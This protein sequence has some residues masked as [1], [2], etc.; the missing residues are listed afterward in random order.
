MTAT[1]PPEDPPGPPQ[2]PPATR[3]TGGADW[4]PR[5]HVIRSHPGLTGQTDD[6]GRLGALV[7]SIR[8]GKGLSTRSLARRSTVARSTIQRLERGLLRPRRSLL[9]AV[10]NGLDP[11]RC[12]E[13]IGKLIE[14]AG[15]GMAPDT[16]RWLRRRRRQM[17][18]GWL[19]GDVP[20]PSPIARCIELHKRAD[21]LWLASQAIVD[22]PGAL[23]DA[24]ALEESSQL[25]AEAARIRKQAGPPI[26]LGTGSRSVWFGY[27]IP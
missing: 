2:D 12:K 16:P 10:A 8:I 21:E 17:E 26:R 22:R 4:L 9:L 15:D 27:H 1:T 20:L 5:A 18:R 24:G 13:L 23:D 3:R 14:A 6:L 25:H 7:R 19:T 11:D